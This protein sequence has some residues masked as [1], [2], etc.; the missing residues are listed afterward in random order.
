MEFFKQRTNFNFMG[1]KTYCV[2]LAIILSVA[3]MGL[4]ITKGLNYGLEF[5]EQTE[6]QRLLMYTYVFNQMAIQEHSSN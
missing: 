2:G 3:A 5:T 4:L 6:E 1:L